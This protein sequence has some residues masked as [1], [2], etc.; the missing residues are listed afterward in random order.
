MYN[1]SHGASSHNS[2]HETLR[3]SGTRMGKKGQ[4]TKLLR[5]AKEYYY[6]QLVRIYSSNGLCGAPP[7]Q[8]HAEGLF[9]QQRSCKKTSL[10]PSSI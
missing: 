6:L 7:L 8:R 2:F 10:Q 3:A 4:E 5:A 9:S 1:V